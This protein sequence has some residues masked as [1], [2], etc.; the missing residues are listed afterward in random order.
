MSI[1]YSRLPL[2]H[3]QKKLNWTQRGRTRRRG[4]VKVTCFVHDVRACKLLS[5]PHPK[6][7]IRAPE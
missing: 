1:Y 2:G 6:G 7:A 3:I 5:R 4:Q